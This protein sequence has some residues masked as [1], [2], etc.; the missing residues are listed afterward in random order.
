MTERNSQCLKTLAAE[1][2]ARTKNGPRAV[3]LEKSSGLYKDCP[4]DGLYFGKVM[5]K[6]KE[7][8]FY[9]VYDS[10]AKASD[11]LSDLSWR[12]K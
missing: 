1:I 11:I 6:P 3:F 4:Q 2:L 10:L 7:F 9:G 8:I 12:P 5:N